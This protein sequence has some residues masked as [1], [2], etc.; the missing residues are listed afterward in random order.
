[1]EIEFDSKL[2]ILSGETGA[3]KSIIVDSLFLLLGAKY[4]KSLL[5]Y[6]QA[7]GLVEGVF[8]V[9]NQTKK[10]LDEF[11]IEFDCDIIVTRKFMADGKN[12]IR[13]NG[14]TA[15]ISMLR[16]I[17]NTLV[18]IY[19]QN[20]HLTLLEKNQQLKT[21]EFFEKT[22]IANISQQV[23]NTYHSYKDTKRQLNSFG[24]ESSR[25]R[26]IEILKSQIDEIVE[27]NVQD[28]EEE[29]LVKERKILLL[30]EKIKFAL[31]AVAN[32][33]CDDDNNI[34]GSLNECKSN[35]SSIRDL[36]EYKNLYQRV[37]SSKIELEDIGYTARS[38][39]Q[40]LDSDQTNIEKIERRL[41][42]V[43]KI[44]RKYGDAKDCKQF[45]DKSQSRLD[46][47]CDAE[48]EVQKLVDKLNKYKR[49][50][51][52]Q[53]C[54]LSEKR[55]QAAK[56]L[57]TAVIAELDELGMNSAKFEV[58]FADIPSIDDCESHFS[59]NGFDTVEYYLSTNK[60]QPIKP[61]AKVISGGE[62]SR[63]MLAI[64]VIMA[65]IESIDT[66]IFDEIDTGISG[67]IG[68]AVAKKL[69]K[70]SRYKQVL[71]VSHLSQIVAMADKNYLITKTDIEQKTT[72]SI[73]PI[74]DKQKL[75]EI[76]R[77]SGGLSSDTALQAANELLIWSQEYKAKIDNTCIQQTIH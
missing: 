69:A 41:E 55:R 4:D 61:L 8:E 40:R 54:K 63:F 10:L 42:V 9:G 34:I 77:L 26:E 52:E 1:M 30:S 72:T 20:Q 68:Q 43:R 7:F 22:T 60:G 51:Y 38:L 16:D 74:G 71:C 46:L 65:Q 47:L 25:S 37:E 18:D 66:L 62:M 2:N 32:I 58:R 53:C 70:I 3:G 67:V 19:G 44:K 14:R 27:S 23:Y 73:V 28:G 17:T 50:L 12:E 5:S 39:C 45:L 48:N 29:N 11:L 59:S 64:K 13:I 33:I 57:E 75:K 56:K 6:G 24:D 76:A 35:L 21:V 31:G 49:E 36:D 15:S